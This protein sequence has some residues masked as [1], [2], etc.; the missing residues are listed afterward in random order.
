MILAETLHANQ[1]GKVLGP[2]EISGRFRLISVMLKFDKHVWLTR[3]ATIWVSATASITEFY[4]LTRGF[5]LLL[6]E[7]IL[8][9]LVLVTFLSFQQ[10]QG[11]Y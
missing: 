10:G 4:A 8:L 11:I 1:V 6:L 7:T 5:I 3:K 9:L 2:I